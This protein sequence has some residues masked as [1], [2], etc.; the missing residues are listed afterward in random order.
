MGLQELHCTVLSMFKQIFFSCL[1][2]A[3]LGS[4]QHV[5]EEDHDHNEEFET[6]NV[7]SN[8]LGFNNGFNNRQF[9]VGP[10]NGRFNN[11]FNN[12]GLNNQVFNPSLNN[13]LNNPSLNPGLNPAGLNNPSINNPGLNQFAL[14]NNNRFG[15]NPIGFN[16]VGLNNVGLNNGLNN[17]GLNNPAFN[18]VGLN[19]AGFNTAG[20]F[21]RPGLQGRTSFGAPSFGN[22]NLLRGARSGLGAFGSRPFGAQTLGGQG[23]FAYNPTVPRQFVSGLGR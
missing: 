19:N 22:T 7:G 11:G 8:T 1:V 2:V 13:G 23:G 21:N 6:I 12:I 15:Q 16:N 4:P 3:I 20:Q 5:E 14:N 10:N 17:V 9:N 18:N